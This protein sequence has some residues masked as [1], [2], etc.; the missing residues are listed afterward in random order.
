MIHKVKCFARI[1][2]CGCD[3]ITICI[4]AI[5]EKYIWIMWASLHYDITTITNTQLKHSAEQRQ[6]CLRLLFAVMR[7]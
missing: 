6:I 4:I 1:T 2:Y 3:I 7:E 5:L